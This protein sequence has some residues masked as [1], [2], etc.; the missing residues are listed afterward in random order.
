MCC[1]WSF[2]VVVVMMS[3]AGFISAAPPE[4]RPANIRVSVPTEASLTIDGRPTSSTSAIRRFVTPP[5]E[6]GKAYVYTMRAEFTRDGSTVTVERKV[7]VRAG[8]EIVVSLDVVG[9]GVVATAAPA[10]SAVSP[11]FYSAEPRSTSSS[12]GY[13]RSERN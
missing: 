1:R 6:E 5:L 11:S 2:V 12:R 8:Q 13:K 4:G 3:I 9:V 10:P 7:S